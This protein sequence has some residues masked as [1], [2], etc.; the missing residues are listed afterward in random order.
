[1]RTPDLFVCSLT[2]Q[3]T[4]LDSKG[5][6]QNHSCCRT[7]HKINI[8]V[9]HYK[10]VPSQLMLYT[11]A[12]GCNADTPKNSIRY[13]ESSTNECTAHGYSLLLEELSCSLVFTWNSDDGYRRNLSAHVEL[14]SFF[15][16]LLAITLFHVLGCP[17][18]CTV[19]VFCTN[20]Q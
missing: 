20:L 5:L 11:K 7:L 1:M 15:F 19:F 4:E 10:K 12:F 17:S 8:L 3:M 13:F 16:C 2:V 9:C 14:P 18:T 6:L